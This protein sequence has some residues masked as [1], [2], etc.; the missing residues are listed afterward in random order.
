MSTRRAEALPELPAAIGERM[1]DYNTKP[2]QKRPGP[3][4]NRLVVWVVS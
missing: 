4:L 1:K 3:R 2:F